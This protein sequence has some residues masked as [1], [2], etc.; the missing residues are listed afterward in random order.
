MLAI[1]TSPMQIDHHLRPLDL[2]R[3]LGPV[4]DLIEICFA[5]H[6]DADGKEYLRQMRRAARDSSF[7]HWALG[8]AE[9][10]SM[11]LSGY[12]WEESGQVVGNLSLVPLIKQHH[13][14]YLIANVAV[15]PDYRRRGIARALTQRALDHAQGHG[16][17]SAWLQ[18]RED[19]PSAY[20]LYRSLGFVDRARR[21]SWLSQGLIPQTSWLPGL[22]ISPR[23]SADWPRQRAWLRQ[24]YPPEVTWNL[25]LSFNRY[26]SGV[27]FDMLRFI[28]ATDIRHWSVR[29]DGELAGV[30]T[31]E[32][33]RM[34]ADNLWLALSPSSPE[35]AISALLVHARN[36]LP[37]SRALSINFPAG[38]H[39]RAFVAAGFLAQQTL[40]WMEAGF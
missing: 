9:T 5:D 38:Q 30:L 10:V 25:P 34:S 31:W 21:T 40:I 11:P 14:I 16:A 3:D 19:N 36:T 35:E 20:E 8:A 15:H 27:L 4:A 39:A 22:A 1:E 2:R 33:S 12:V 28:S 18:V 37:H 13:A 6:M 26:R 24:A 17:A 7:L 32:P 29:L 23:R